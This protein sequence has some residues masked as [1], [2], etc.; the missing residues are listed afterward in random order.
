MAYLPP[1]VCT[2]RVRLRHR[3]RSALISSSG[4]APESAAR[5]TDQN[6]VSLFIK[7]SNSSFCSRSTLHSESYSA[8]SLRSRGACGVLLVAGR[9]SCA[10]KAG[11]HAPVVLSNPFINNSL[12]L[13]L[14]SPPSLRLTGYDVACANSLQHTLPREEQGGKMAHA[15]GW[16][17]QR[18]FNFSCSITSA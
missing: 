7:R 6:Q 10:L 8:V 12:H 4:P 9:G 18:T 3:Q 1:A 16:G 14:L 15:A 2:D 13:A 11:N 17:Q 5:G